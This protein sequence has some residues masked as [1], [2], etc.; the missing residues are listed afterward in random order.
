MQAKKYFTFITI[1]YAKNS[2]YFP[3]EICLSFINTLTFQIVIGMN[4]HLLFQ[5]DCSAN[6]PKDHTSY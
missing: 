1:H 4:I 6:I 2:A 5:I 3:T